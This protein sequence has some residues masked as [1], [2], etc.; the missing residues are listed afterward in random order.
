MMDDND[1]QWLQSLGLEEEEMWSAPLLTE[2]IGNRE[3][4]NSNLTG[5]RNPDRRLAG[6]G[7]LNDGL[8]IYSHRTG[9][10]AFAQLFYLIT[11]VEL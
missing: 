8:L 5:G 1:N 9:F 4:R 10:I 2:N 7:F 3:F 11:P 6:P